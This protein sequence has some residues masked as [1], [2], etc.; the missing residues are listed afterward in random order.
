MCSIVIEEALTCYALSDH[1]INDSDLAS[2]EDWDNSSDD[3]NLDLDEGYGLLRSWGD[4]IL[5]GVAGSARSQCTEAMFDALTTC[6]RLTLICLPSQRRRLWRKLTA[7]GMEGGNPLAVPG[8][9][10]L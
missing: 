4:A 8:T 5:S 3:D 7:Q 6:V 10:S 2:L 9:K 1:D